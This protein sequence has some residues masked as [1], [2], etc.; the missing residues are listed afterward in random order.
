MLAETD[1]V[2]TDSFY[3][4]CA[5]R[6]RE[7]SLCAAAGSVLSRCDIPRWHIASVNVVYSIIVICI[8]IK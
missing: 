7:F 1:T 8:T 4:Q 2:L 6:V 3:F 5:V